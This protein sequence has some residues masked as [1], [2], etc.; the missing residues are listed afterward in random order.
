MQ[1]KSLRTD[2]LIFFFFYL[3]IAHSGTV[4]HFLIAIALSVKLLPRPPI[5][6]A[7]RLKA[8]RLMAVLT[9]LQLVG[10]LVVAYVVTLAVCVTVTTVHPTGLVENGRWRLLSDV[11]RPLHGSCFRTPYGRVL[12]LLQ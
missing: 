10:V 1:D 3:T 4:G 11:V 12:T 2:T 9:T 5:G 7:H 6:G 8:D